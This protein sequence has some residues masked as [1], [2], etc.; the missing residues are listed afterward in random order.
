MKNFEEKFNRMPTPTIKNI[1]LNL[2]RFISES[3]KIK[4]K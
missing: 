3:I 1:L 2:K 4:L